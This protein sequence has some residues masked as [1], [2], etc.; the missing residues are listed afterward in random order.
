[1]EAGTLVLVEAW[2]KEA[3]SDGYTREAPI[4]LD[5]W[6]KLFGDQR[7]FSAS[8]IDAYFKGNV[9]DVEDQS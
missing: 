2:P 1:M 6:R 7:P 4:V 5:A 3:L 9:K 8:E